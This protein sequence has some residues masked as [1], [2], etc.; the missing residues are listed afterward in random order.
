MGFSFS[1]ISSKITGTK[2]I[3]IKVNSDTTPL[4]ELANEID[5]LN[6]ANLVLPD[7]KKTTAKLCWWKGRKLELRIHFASNPMTLHKV[8]EKVGNYIS[9]NPELHIPDNIKI[10]D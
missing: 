2:N 3:T 7:L 1:G 9:N 5:W 8:V 10:A 4:I 6:L